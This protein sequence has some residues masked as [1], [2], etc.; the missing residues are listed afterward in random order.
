ML[1]ASVLLYAIDFHG[2]FVSSWG[3]L[4]HSFGMLHHDIS[5]GTKKDAVLLAFTLFLA[6]PAES[7]MR[8]QLQFCRIL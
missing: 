4:F 6:D 7:A 8:A 2:C 3:I 1:S 5:A